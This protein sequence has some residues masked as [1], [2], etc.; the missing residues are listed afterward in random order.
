M[1]LGTFWLVRIGVV[2]VLTGLVFFGNLAYQNYISRL[3]PGGKVSLLYL[4]SA[5]LLV[6]GWWW[7]R[8]AVKDTLR[9]YAQV[10]F[11]G[12]L[13]ALYFTT[14]A[15][16]HLERLRIIQSAALDGVL[17]LLCA[18]FMIWAAE[19]KK[20]QV[21]AFFAVGLAYYT[22]I[23][24][25]VGTF[26]LWSNLVLSAA[27]VFFLVR[28]R[29]AAL[30][31]GSLIATYMAY[32]FWRFFDGSNW[33]WASP[34]EGLWFGTI[35]LMFYWL[36]FTTAVF[37]SRDRKF[38][39][40]NRASFLTLNNGAFFT[41]FILTM[42]Q[43]QQGGLWKFCLMYGAVLLALALASGRVLREEPLS[44]N[45]YLTQGLLLITVGFISKFA[46]LQLALILATESVLLL[47]AGQQRKNLVLLTGAYITAA[48]AVGWGMD[49]LKQFDS[50]SLWL[51][52]GL[53]VLMMVNAWLTNR[54]L[55]AG[56]GA[57]TES[58]LLLRP[59]PAYFTVLAF[60]IWLVATWDNTS[61]DIF[62]LA[63]AAEAMVLSFSIYL[64][65]I[66]EVTIFSQAVMLLAQGAWFLNWSDGSSFLPW[67]NPA[68]LIVISLIL[69]HWWPRQ[70]IINPKHQ[71]GLIWP[72]L[73]GL[74]VNL[75]LYMWLA[76]KDNAPSW[77]VTTSLLAIGLTIYGVATRAWFVAV[78]AQLFLVIAVLQFGLQVS[79]AKPP[80]RFPLAPIAVLGLL[81]FG[82]V[83]WFKRT[84]NADSRVRDPL[85]L[86]ALIYRWVGL[87][88]SIAWICVYLSTRERIWLL[89]LLGLCVFLWAGWQR[90]RE[91][92]LFSAA[93]TLSALALFW[94][95]LIET[96]TVYL[97]NL[98]VILLLLVQRQIAR[99][100]P[101]RYPLD[102]AVHSAVIVVGG[103]SLWLFVSRWVL[104]M[105]RDFYL[106]ASW[107]VLALILFTAG[108]L[109]RERMYR[110]IGLGILACALGRVVVFDVWK[111]ETVYRVLS[112]M[113]LGIVLLVLGFIYSKYQEKIKEWL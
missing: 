26:T 90:N 79:E 32:G 10:L 80:M 69:S 29:W 109:L 1:R 63:I 9:N 107:S 81:S 104:E 91:A 59:Q 74:A 45:A 76:P 62:P 18:G 89:A 50:P 49:G 4:A 102:P 110:W 53:G 61:R 38:A 30:S 13:A 34:E 15:A 20:S 39:G 36:V 56:G 83:K 67:W 65:R 12:G 19:R 84:P 111:L 99:R 7:Q 108:L 14:Y 54:Q 11:A 101:E 47:I 82:T 8:K 25:R 106:T 97:P 24:T 112:F 5:G 52:A 48:L 6:A 3:G 60:V 70:H 103:L 95:P 78:C 93:F 72:A 28:N 51:G 100:S 31:F 87:V 94:L 44:G 64:L 85:L 46:G 27:A 16:H 98:A 71:N 33:H 73:Y 57:K 92:L 105:A 77:L 96:S 58:E 43:V 41:L 113:A 17:L 23:I 66:P 86:I 55:I 21:L 42:L 75:V 40:Q 37:L 2:M 22:S 68:I 88:L 35:F